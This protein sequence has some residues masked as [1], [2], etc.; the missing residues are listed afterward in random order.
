MA[1]LTSHS[2]R[3]RLPHARQVALI[4]DF[5]DWNSAAHPLVQ[6]APGLWERAVNLPAGKHRYAF[7]VVEDARHDGGVPRTRVEGEGAVLWVPENPEHAVSVTSYPARVGAR[8]E[9]QEAVLQAA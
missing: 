9:R 6:V 2:I 8:H 3:V 5:N 4:G 7:F 1:R